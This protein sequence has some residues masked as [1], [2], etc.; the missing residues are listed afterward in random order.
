MQE[1]N[2]QN[3]YHEAAYMDDIN[4]IRMVRNAGGNPMARDRSGKT[5]FSISLKKDEQV[6]KEILG[7]SH[8]ITDSDG[9]TPPHVVVTS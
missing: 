4:I 2:G 3:A 1:V 6:I 5:P 8:T 9:N 7:K